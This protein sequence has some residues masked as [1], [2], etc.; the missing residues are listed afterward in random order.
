VKCFHCGQTGH[1]K[2]QCPKL[3]T[4][5]AN[6]GRIEE[7]DGDAN[8]DQQ[9]NVEYNADTPVD[10]H[11]DNHQTDA[12][13]T[14][15]DTNDYIGEYHY[16]WD[17]DNE[18]YAA[19][20]IF[21]MDDG[22]EE[23]RLNFVSKPLTKSTDPSE[24]FPDTGKEPIYDHTA[25]VKSRAPKR[26]K[27]ASKPI[28]GFWPVNGQLAHCLVDSGCQGM[29]MS[30]AFSRATGV[31]TFALNKPVVLQLAVK[32]SKSSIQYGTYTRIEFGDVNVIEYFDIVNIDYYD[33]IIGVPF[34]RRYEIQLD[35]KLGTITRNGRVIDANEHVIS[36]SDVET[37]DMDAMA[38]AFVKAEPELTPDHIPE[39][40]EYWKTL[41]S[42]L[43]GDV[44]LELPPFRKVNHHIP[45]IDPNKK[46]RYHL[47][48]CPDALSLL[49]R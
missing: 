23:R 39:L 21:P 28:E 17:D 46:I 2:S 25:R 36:S 11:Q 18:D 44:P 33:V 15:E 45:L 32:G 1:Y 29:I 14:P 27:E 48:R 35:F 30:P 31:R 5:R 41:Y 38:A 40:I 26:E 6:V 49:R 12:N 42:D 8:E 4:I 22:Y 43:F 19:Y 34:L 37:Y 10:D 9:G 13:N 24:S 16:Q 3:K 47:P 7:L 20:M